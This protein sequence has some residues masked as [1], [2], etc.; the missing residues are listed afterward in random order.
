VS[1]SQKIVRI[2]GR[3]RL[4]VTRNTDIDRTDFFDIGWRKAASKLGLKIDDLGAGYLKISGETGSIKIHGS[5]L[6]VDDMLS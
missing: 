1:F 4:A 2:T 3:V 5:C 6:S